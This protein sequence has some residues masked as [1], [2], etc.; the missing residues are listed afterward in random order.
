MTVKDIVF[1]AAF[2]LLATLAFA[3]SVAVSVRYPQSPA[4]PCAPSA[5][6]DL[7]RYC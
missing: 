1:A 3:A 2:T 7:L 5:L 4:G 6:P